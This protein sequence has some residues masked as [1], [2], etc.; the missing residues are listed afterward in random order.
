[1]YYRNGYRYNTA[2]KP[3]VSLLEV[4]ILMAVIKPFRGVRY[5]PDRILNMSAVISQPY[6]RIG[7][8]LEQEYYNLSP[9]NIT[10]IILG[11]DEDSHLPTNFRNGDGYT[12]AK[13]TYLQWL[14][15]GVL[16]RDEKPALYAYEQTFT[17][18]GQTYTRLGM[19]AALELA[20]FDEGI[21]LPHERTHSGPKAD[22]LRLMEAM[23][24]N[25]EQIFMLYP[26]P[27]NRINAVL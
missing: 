9:Y 17:V 22:R 26:D 24:V 1:M 27:H 18:D 25:T 15:S 3:I 11:H 13:E 4:L 21:V 12:K 19:T 6:D 14:E 23:A 2:V 20:E 8:A 16:H 5:N 10:R 7:D